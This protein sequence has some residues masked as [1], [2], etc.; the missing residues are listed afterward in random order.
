MAQPAPPPANLLTMRRFHKVPKEIDDS[1]PFSGFMSG[2]RMVDE[3]R[4]WFYIRHPRTWNDYVTFL[5][6]WS[7]KSGRWDVISDPYGEEKEDLLPDGARRFHPNATLTKW[8]GD[9][10]IGQWH[11]IKR[12]NPALSK[13]EKLD[14]PAPGDIRLFVANNK[15]Y[16]A[17][18]ESIFEITEHGRS[19]VVLASNRRRPAVS[20]LDSAESF[21][22]PALFPGPDGSLRVAF[23]RRVSAWDGRDW[24]PV[25]TPEFDTFDLMN[26]DIILR[27][28]RH[29]SPAELW[30][31]PNDQVKPELVW[32]EPWRDPQGAPA[33]PFRRGQLDVPLGK[34]RWTSTNDLRLA[35]AAFSKYGSALLFLIPN[36]PDHKVPNTQFVPVEFEGRHANLVVLDPAFKEPLVIPVKFDIEHGDYPFNASAGTMV[37]PLGTRPWLAVLKNDLVIG[38]TEMHGIWIMT[39]IELDAALDRERTRMRNEAESPPGK[40]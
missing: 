4:I 34:A 29:M 33:P 9:L 32:T 11:S 21:G 27:R 24:N 22:Q 25:R 2:G 8:E 5:A 31:L 37:N 6:V 28:A 23:I 14:L 17:S 15:L 12:F 36:Y 1:T 3:D 18:E 7:A 39:R 38:R 26:Q 16:G 35:N 10:Y 40:N 20:S 13:W 19:A 30:W